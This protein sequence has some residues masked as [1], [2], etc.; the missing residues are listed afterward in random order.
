MGLLDTWVV[1]ID[2]DCVTNIHIAQTHLLVRFYYFQID[3]SY[4]ADR[5]IDATDNLDLNN[6]L[7]LLMHKFEVVLAHT[8]DFYWL[9]RLY[10]HG[11]AVLHLPCV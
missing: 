3:F 10:I 9:L 6:S 11:F 8:L 5:R 4:M 7:V 1:A 2:Y